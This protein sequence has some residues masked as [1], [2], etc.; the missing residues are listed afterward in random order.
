MT[1]RVGNDN[2]IERYTF[3]GKKGKTVVDYVLKFI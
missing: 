3:V 2:A 1:G